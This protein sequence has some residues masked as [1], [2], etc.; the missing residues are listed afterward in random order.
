[1]CLKTHNVIANLP[2]HVLIFFSCVWIGMCLWSLENPALDNNSST[3][4]TITN[5]SDSDTESNSVPD[6]QSVY[7]TCVAA[8]SPP[9]NLGT[10]R[11]FSQ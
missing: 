3:N 4:P 6:A 7:E 2:A 1:M 5:L 10:M 11:V 8:S 9:I